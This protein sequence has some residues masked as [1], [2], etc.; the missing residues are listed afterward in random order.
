MSSAQL[1]NVPK[2]LTLSCVLL[3]V[4]AVSPVHAQFT[5]QDLF[6]FDNCF[7]GLGCE[8]KGQWTQGADGNLYGTG[9]LGGP[10]DHGAIFM[11]TPSGAFTNVLSFNGTTGEDPEGGLIL[12][13][14]GNFYGTTSSGGSFGYGTL[15]RLTPSAVF[16]VLHQFKNST[17]GGGP[18]APPDGGEGWKSLWRNGGWNRVSR[19]AT[20]GNFQVDF[21]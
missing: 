14:D 17:D 2:R 15:F 12:A 11:M 19:Y 8:P 5:Y 3:L 9:F 4:F 10:H 7:T 21:D 13:S 20:S 16:T 6:E 18:F 1:L